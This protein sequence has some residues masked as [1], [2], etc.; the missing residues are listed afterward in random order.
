MHAD[1]KVSM[2]SCSSQA[3]L[4]AAALFEDQE[5]GAVP[6]MPT[7]RTRTPAAPD[8]RLVRLWSLPL[9]SAPS[10]C[11]SAGYRKPSP[12]LSLP[13]QHFRTSKRS[14][15]MVPKSVDFGT[16]SRLREK[17]PGPKAQLNQGR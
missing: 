1:G 2:M 5:W 6:R 4:I 13:T 8:Y 17:K 12:K 9:L 10:R 7:M 16:V 11:R 14:V 3:A 15:L